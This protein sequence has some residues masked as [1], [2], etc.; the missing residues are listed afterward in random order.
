MI[1]RISALLIILSIGVSQKEYDIINLL[2]Q[3]G[4]YK[5]K[6]NDDILNGIIYRILDNKK[7][8]LGNLKNGKKDG[9]WTEWYPNKRKLEE[10]Y[11]HGILDGS[12]RLFYKTGQRRMKAYL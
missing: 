3:G 8:I 11:K 6:F 1:N 4:V 12:V 9:L 10:T 5:Q 2:N 7:V